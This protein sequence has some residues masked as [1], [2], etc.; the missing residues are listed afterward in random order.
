MTI[1]TT[2]ARLRFSPIPAAVAAEARQTR[3]DRFGHDLKVYRDRAPCRVCLRI[4]E[5]P[6][7]L[8]L[9]SYRPLPDRTPYAEIGP[10]FIHEHECAPYERF[11]VLP[12]DFRSRALVLRA[13]DGDGAIVDAAVAAP[14]EAES[15]A[16]TFFAN[17]AVAE[18]HVRHTTYTCFDFKIERG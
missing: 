3:K 4:S 11:D 18:V 2:K 13:Y 1:T 17:A 10:I 14:G 8:I 16:S 7:D 15:L 5:E 9:L 6:E 12:E